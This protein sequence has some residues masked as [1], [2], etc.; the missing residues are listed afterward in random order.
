MLE[1]IFLDNTL[2]FLFVTIIIVVVHEYGHYFFAKLCGVHIDVFSV[3][4]GPKLYSFYDKAKTRWQI[5]A[6]PL[7]G[8]VK[9]NGQEAS[10]NET[11]A[12]KISKNDKTNFINKNPLQKISIAF[13]G[14]LF[15]FILAIIIIF[16]IFISYGKPEI[17][18]TISEILPNSPAEKYGLL[19]NDKILKINNIDI[20]SAEDIINQ[21]QKIENNNVTILV[22]NKNTESREIKIILN[23]E[24]KLGIKI[25]GEISNQKI[26]ITS[27]LSESIKYTFY[28][29][30]MS[31]IGIKR[32]FFG[33]E[34]MKN[35]GG[36]IQ[37]AKSS[38]DAM[39]S[40]FENFLFLIA[41]LS[42]NLAILNLLPIPGLDGG[43]ILFYLFDL[44][45]IGKFI[46]PKA[47]V[48]AVALGFTILIGLM[49]IANSNDIIKLLNN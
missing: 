10:F 33:E 21:L 19:I 23:N 6:L 11:E 38:G 12:A 41:L 22:K 5:C 44:L 17:Q 16:I 29:T 20:K 45:W 48:Y 28:I 8:F 3:G 1:S 40:G 2:A 26:G 15:N 36:V 18:P 46:K 25:G 37:I 9:I 49:I 43:H 13:G 35:L 30:K 47:R 24:N 34:K 32:L 14:P 4:F 39:R 7:G 27:A 42:I 31:V